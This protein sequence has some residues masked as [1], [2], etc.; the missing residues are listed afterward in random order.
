[1]GLH[2]RAPEQLNAL[3][4]PPGALLKR[5]TSHET[6]GRYPFLCADLLLGVVLIYFLSVVVHMCGQYL[7]LD[8]ILKIVAH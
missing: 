8:N 6:D 1:M 2:F 4:E 5:Q 3:L 7:S